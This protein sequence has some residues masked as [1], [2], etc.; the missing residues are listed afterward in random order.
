MGGETLR[1]RPD[2]PWGPPSFLYNGHRISFLGVKRPERGVGDPPP[3]GAE[4]KESRAIPLLPIWAFV[5]CYRVNCAFYLYIYCALSASLY[6]LSV[7]TEIVRHTG[8][9]WCESLNLTIRANCIPWNSK[10]GKMK[11]KARIYTSKPTRTYGRTWAR[12]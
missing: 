5:A 12:R 10:S 2:R 3:S 7:H 6:G 4:V 9:E 1:T 8:C 11:I